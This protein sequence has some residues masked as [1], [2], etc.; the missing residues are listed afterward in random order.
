MTTFQPRSGADPVVVCQFT[1][2]ELVRC[3]GW[4]TQFALTQ[5]HHGEA[6]A[7]RQFDQPAAKSAYDLGRRWAQELIERSGALSPDRSFGGEHDLAARLTE[8]EAPEVA[9][10]AYGY[11]S[12]VDTLPDDIALRAVGADRSNGSR[13]QAHVLMRVLLW[14]GRFDVEA[15]TLHEALQTAVGTLLPAR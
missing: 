13:S 9:E 7:A 15:R 12:V 10:I 4:M 6:P 5:Q 1:L 11:L 14:A 8:L 3:I 2:E